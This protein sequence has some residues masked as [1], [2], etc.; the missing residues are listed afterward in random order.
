MRLDLRI[1]LDSPI[2]S[3]KIYRVFWEKKK[4]NLNVEINPQKKIEAK[5]L[6]INSIKF[7]NSLCDIYA[8]TVI[9][10]QKLL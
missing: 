4:Q 1:S 6:A 7:E 3:K 8:D 9:S 5:R 2:F 10:K